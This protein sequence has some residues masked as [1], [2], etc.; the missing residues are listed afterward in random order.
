MNCLIDSLNNDCSSD[1]TSCFNQTEAANDNACSDYCFVA[2]LCESL[3]EDQSEFDCV[4]EC[5]MLVATEDPIAFAPYQSQIACAGQNSCQ[6]FSDCLSGTGTD[7]AC[8][9]L[10]A[11]RASCG[12]EDEMA[13]LSRCNSLYATERSRR[14]RTCGA[15]LSCE[16]NDLCQIP[17]APNCASYCAPVEAC[18]L[19]TADCITQCDNAELYQPESHLPRLT[20]VN[21][22]ERCDYVEECLDDQSNANACL[23]YCAYLSGCSANGEL[24]EPSEGCAV[25]CARG[26]LST[27]DANLF[28]PAASCLAALNPNDASC[29]DVSNCLDNAPSLCEELC[30]LVNGC[31]LPLSGELANNCVSACE[32]GEVSNSEQLCAMSAAQREEGCGAVAGCLGFLISSQL[33]LVLS[34]AMLSSFV[35][36]V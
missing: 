29:G 13:C 19:A 4:E 27:E 20:C 26:E 33:L 17:Q 16:S 31:G 22:S 12:V 14:E 21:A 35:T 8:V 9:D 32:A 18:G 15:L 6:A 34:T 2:S 1:L 11:Q 25:S 23:N 3:P 24:G 5:Q 36:L 30:S 7:D 28:L 10:C